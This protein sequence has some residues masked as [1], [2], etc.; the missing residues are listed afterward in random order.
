MS[1]SPRFQSPGYL[2]PAEVGFVRIA[3]ISIA[4]ISSTRGGGFCL[5]RRD[6]NR[7][8]RIA[9]ISIAGIS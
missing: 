4:G 1:V 8:G 6:F 7:R 2:Q 5:Y 3:A 9:A